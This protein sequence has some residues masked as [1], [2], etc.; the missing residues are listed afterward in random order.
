MRKNFFTSRFFYTFA[1]KLKNHYA[2]TDKKR[3]D[4]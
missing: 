2:H 1:G 4:S 3:H